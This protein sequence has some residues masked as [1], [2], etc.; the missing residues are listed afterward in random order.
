MGRLGRWATLVAVMA[1][2]MLLVIS[3]LAC[4]P[5]HKPSPPSASTP[6]V[7]VRLL[8]A[9]D[10]VAIRAALAPTVRAF[11][12]K[13]ALRVNLPGTSDV[14]LTLKDNRWLIGGVPIPGGGVLTMWQADDGTV[15]I[16][17]RTYRGRFRFIPAG[18]NT[19]DVVNDVDID[20]YVKSVVPREL[21]KSWGE[22]A[23]KAQAIVARTY[24]L[25]EARTAGLRRQ[26]DVYPDQRS[27][28]YGGYQ[29][30]SEKS[31]A[32]VDDTTGVVVAYGQLNHERIFK[33]YFSA[34]CG[35]VTQSAADAFGEA[36]QVPLS[37]QNLHGLCSAANNYNWGPVEISK[38]ELTRRLR[39][40][41]KRRGRAE[42]DMAKV[43]KLEIQLVN[44]FNRPIRFVVTDTNGS[45]FSLTGEELRNA[46]NAGTS[47]DEPARLLSSFCK[48]V[49]D[50]TSETIRFVDGH[51]NGHGVGLCQWCSEIRSEAGLRHEDIVLSAY[52]RARLVRAY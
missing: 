23:Y 43:S 20:G 52:P 25:Y 42:R 12:E 2:G 29:D 15:S 45:R 49:C 35:G 8:V 4:A 36:Y 30:E 7:R 51:G 46:I 38:D 9:R 6:I 16:N 13:Q 18:G 27:Q 32:A 47:K 17:G 26:W 48:V 14:A 1:A 50:P 40:Y 28:V 31:R 44:R 3:P 22:E 34:C 41:G 39:D 11:S 10:N 5:R 33:T 24:A 19:F 21:L 37:D